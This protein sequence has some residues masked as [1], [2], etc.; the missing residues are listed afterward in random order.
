ML[1]SLPFLGAC[2]V[3]LSTALLATNPVEARGGGHGGGHHGGGHHGGHHGG[4]AHHSSHHSHHSHHSSHHS[5]HGT[6]NNG[7]RGHGYGGYGGWGGWGGWGRG[8]YGYAPAWRGYYW[9]SPNYYYTGNTVASIPVTTAGTATNTVRR[10]PASE[11]LIDVRVPSDATVWFNGN[12]T[13]QS[14]ANRE[15][16]ASGLTPGQNY[17][18]SVRARWTDNGKV[19][20]RTRNIVIHGGERRT[21]EF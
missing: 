13:N 20:D 9:G 19:V 4:H 16:S 15:Y 7:G 10:P 8:Y 12:V 3:T 14:G 17:D 2:A 18:Y 6:H 21:L 5:H 1:R 11:A